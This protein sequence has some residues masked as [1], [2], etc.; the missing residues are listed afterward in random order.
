MYEFT[1]IA[2]PVIKELINKNLYK[3]RFYIFIETYDDKKS[4]ILPL[5]C[6]LKYS[7]RYYIH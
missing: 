5:G 3:I 1:R 7:F 4:S 2:R 6:G